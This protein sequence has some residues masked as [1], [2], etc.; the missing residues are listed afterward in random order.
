MYFKDVAYLLKN[1]Q[2][3]NNKN[4]PINSFTEE[5]IYCNSKSITQSEFYQ[6]ATVGLKPTI[7]L[8]CKLIDV[9]GVDHVKYNN[10]IYKILRS[11]RKE[12]KIEITLVRTIMENNQSV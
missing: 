2:T 3:L 9:N 10:E 7:K 8:E 6:S 11:Y 4:K 12:D 5:K 1:T